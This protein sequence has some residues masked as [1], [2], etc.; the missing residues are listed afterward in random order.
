MLPL[1]SSPS[2]RWPEPIPLAGHANQQLLQR[3]LKKQCPPKSQRTEGGLAFVFWVAQASKVETVFADLVKRPH[4]CIGLCPVMKVRPSPT[5]RLVQ[6]SRMW[7]DVDTSCQLSTPLR[8]TTHHFSHPQL[9]GCRHSQGS[10]HGNQSQ[11][12]RQTA[13][14][15]QV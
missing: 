11:F 1:H 2:S 13:P 8:H 4:L 12:S 15:G 9:L 7:L 14:G 10:P 3:F 6:P 5:L